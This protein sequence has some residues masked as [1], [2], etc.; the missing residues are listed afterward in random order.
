[1]RLVI[2][3]IPMTQMKKHVSKSLPSHK[4]HI[5]IV[6]LDIIISHVVESLNSTNWVGC[7]NVLSGHGLLLLFNNFALAYRHTHC[8]TLSQWDSR[9]MNHGRRKSMK[10]RR[11]FLAKAWQL[12]T[13]TRRDLRKGWPASLRQWDSVLE[14]KD[15]WQNSLWRAMTRLLLTPLLMQSSRSAWR[16][17]A[18]STQKGW[19]ALQERASGKEF[20]YSRNI[21]PVISRV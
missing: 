3:Y 7:V 13:Q 10:Y 2:F 5:C 6:S 9:T 16:R 11:I 8:T 19:E 15:W 18:L 20:A 4:F 1:M 17:F 21:P 14:N 12:I